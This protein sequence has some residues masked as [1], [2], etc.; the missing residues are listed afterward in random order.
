ME[1]IEIPGKS[2]HKYRILDI[3]IVDVIGTIIIGYLMGKLLKINVYLTII[4]FF[5]MGEIIH[6]KRNI[7]TTII[8][9]YK[10]K[11]I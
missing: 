9:I 5:I 3:A 11:Y 4:S 2:I 6:Y 7:D 8:K 10:N 1:D